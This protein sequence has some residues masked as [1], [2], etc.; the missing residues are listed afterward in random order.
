MDYGVKWRSGRRKWM[1]ATANYPLIVEVRGED[2]VLQCGQALAAIDGGLAVD[3]RCIYRPTEPVALAIVR[4]AR[5]QEYFVPR[6]RTDGA[7]YE[8]GLSEPV[9]VL[10][11]DCSSLLEPWMWQPAEVVVYDW[12]HRQFA[13]VTVRTR[14]SNGNWTAVK[15][16]VRQDRIRRPS[17]STEAAALFPHEFLNMVSEQCGETINEYYR[18]TVYRP[19]ASEIQPLPPSEVDGDVGLLPCNVVAE[20]MQNLP[21]VDQCRLRAVRAG[22]NYILTSAEVTQLLHINFPT[23]RAP[24][25]GGIYMAVACAQRCWSNRTVA[26]VGLPLPAH[27]EAVKLRNLSLIDAHILTAVMQGRSENFPQHLLLQDIHVQHTPQ[28][29][30]EEDYI[31]SLRDVFNSLAA[32][33]HTLTVKNFTCEV[34]SWLDGYVPITI[35]IALGRMSH[36]R[37]LHIEDWWDMI[38]QGIPVPLHQWHVIDNVI[39]CGL[40]DRSEKIIQHRQSGD[41]RSSTS[42]LK[43]FPDPTVGQPLRYEPAKCTRM[44]QFLL[45]CA[46]LR[47]KP[48]F[49]VTWPAS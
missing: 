13:I 37:R 15:T 22:W 44:V 39:S 10:M 25:P 17:T 18:P 31:N 3:F 33:C 41:P 28:R 46:K 45:Y 7:P 40:S 30:Q 5:T 48:T 26:M 14:D 47:I 29:V 20:I 9:E 42:Y 49:E 38:E 32:I 4:V 11:Q 1:R 43:P 6:T 24:T 8:Q 34:D 16:V 12:A 35:H 21:T 27:H 19:L 2:E 23:D 36:G